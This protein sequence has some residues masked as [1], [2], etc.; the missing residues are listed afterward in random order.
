MLARKFVIWGMNFFIS[1]KVYLKFWDA[2]FTIGAP[3]DLAHA[4]KFAPKSLWGPKKSQ[5]VMCKSDVRIPSCVYVNCSSVA[6]IYKTRESISL[7]SAQTA[8]IMPSNFCT[9]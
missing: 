9:C 8:I 1:E 2:K 4:R 7:T 6:Q 5:N 3:H